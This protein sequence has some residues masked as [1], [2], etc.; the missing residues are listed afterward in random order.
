VVAGAWYTLGATS[1]AAVAYRWLRELA[2]GGSPTSPLLSY[3]EIDRRARRVAPGASGVLF[4]PFLQGERT[5]HWDA[6]LR[7]AFLGLTMGHS[8]DHLA[9]AVLEGVAMG[10][11]ACRDAMVEAGM[12][13]ERPALTGGGLTSPLWRS[14]VVAVLS[15]PARVIEPHGPAIGAATLAAAMGATTAPGIRQ[16]TPPSSVRR[17]TP[18]ADWIATYDAWYQVYR[19]AARETMPT[20][21]RLADLARD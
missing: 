12:R 10:L 21:H 7:G 20:S 3:P 8:R 18:R 17:V 19:D 13:V 11:R 16:H 6:R 14:I 15:R 1:T 9:R 2:Y 4:L 5:P